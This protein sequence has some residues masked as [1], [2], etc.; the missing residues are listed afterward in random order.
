[1]KTIETHAFVCSK[2]Y[3]LVNLF[4]LPYNYENTEVKKI[5]IIIAHFS[6]AEQVAERIRKLC[7]FFDEVLLVHNR[8]SVIKVLLSNKVT[9]FYTDTDVTIKGLI[10]SFLVKE[11]YVYEEGTSNYINVSRDS[12]QSFEGTGISAKMKKLFFYVFRTGNILGSNHKTK[13]IYLYNPGVFEHKFPQLYPKV[14]YF[15]DN[16]FDYLSKKEQFITSIFEKPAS[17]GHIKNEKIVFYVT[18]HDL[19][20]EI[21]DDLEVK[22]NEFDRVIVKFHPH[23]LFKD[24]SALEKIDKA[25]LIVH[26]TI[27][28]EIIFMLLI[29][30]G[31]KLT[32]IHEGSTACLYLNESENVRI[33]NY[34]KDGNYKKSFT[35]LREYYLNN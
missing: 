4:N 12:G 10:Y 16:L 23:L 27:M 34:M 7:P 19:N 20:I 32:I 35:E 22:K 17:I 6:D 13:N 28:V 31:N 11:L 3:Q 26:E 9:R 30:N 24:P 2:P 1:M 14:K 25:F 29:N 15:K 18:G 5:F 33:I 8:K 21:L